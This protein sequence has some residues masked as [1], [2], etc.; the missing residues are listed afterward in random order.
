MNSW[1]Q[2]LKTQNM[3]V[4]RKIPFGSG[5]HY[6]WFVSSLNGDQRYKVFGI[7]INRSLRVPKA[8][9]FEA[10]IC[11]KPATLN[12]G[13][14]K[15][16]EIIITPQM[17]S[18]KNY[19]WENFIWMP[20][21]KHFSISFWSHQELMKYYPML[22]TTRRHSLCKL[23]FKYFLVRLTNFFKLFQISSWSRYL[24]TV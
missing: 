14:P 3:L 15:G 20:M 17:P 13:D 10:Y 19:H 23:L 7:L 2:M 21:P 6:N 22:W 8:K 11:V 4:L 9:R 24:W 16:E 18:T 5:I 1:V 12:R